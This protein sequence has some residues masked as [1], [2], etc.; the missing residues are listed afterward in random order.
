VPQQLFPTAL[1]EVR[2]QIGATT[3]G[4][5]IL[6]IVPEEHF[7]AQPITV[8]VNWLATVQK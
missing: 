2:R 8:V 1:G 4:T 3:D 5:R 7:A 6:V